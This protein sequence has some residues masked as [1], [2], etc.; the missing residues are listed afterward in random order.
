MIDRMA[1]SPCSLASLPPAP[2]SETGSVKVWTAPVVLS[3]YVPEPAD[4]NPMFF[5]DR[6]SQGASGRVYP[7]PIVERIAE[8]PALCSWEA[9][10][11][12]NE[13]LRLMVLPKLGGRIHLGL[14]KIGGHDFFHFEETIQPTAGERTGPAIFGGLEIDWPHRRRAG[15]FVPCETAIA[16]AADGSATIW[17][18]HHDPVTRMKG[19]HGVCLHP[20]RALVQL[21]ARLYNRTEDAHPFVWSAELSAQVPRS[22]QVFFSPEVKFVSER[23]G[24][25]VTDLPSGKR[26]FASAG[27]ADLAQSD[28]DDEAPRQTIEPLSLCA[29]GDFAGIYDHAVHA[30]IVQV[31][32][33]HATRDR[34]MAASGR[35]GVDFL[36]AAGGAQTARVSLCAGADLEGPTVRSSL[37]PGETR[38]F[39]QYWCPLREIGVP[40]AVTLQGALSLRVEPGKAHIGVCVTADVSDAQVLLRSHGQVVARWQRNITVVQPFVAVGRIAL[41]VAEDSLILTVEQRGS[42]LLRYAPGEVVAAPAPLAVSEPAPPEAIAGGELLYLTGLHLL[43]KRHATRRPEPYWFEAVRRDPG[44]ARANTAL[45]SLLL[46][47]GNFQLAENHLHTAIARLNLLGVHP[48]DSEA[49]YRLGIAL[50][51]QGR[52]QEAYSAFLQGTGNAAW[53]G[54]AYQGLAE[55]DARARRWQKTLEHIDRCLAAGAENLNALAVRAL[56]LRHLDREAEARSQLNQALTLDPLHAWSRHILNRTLPAGGQGRLDLAF[57]YMRC[58][59]LADAVSVL[60]AA[61]STADDDDGSAPMRHYTRAVLL[62]RMDERLLSV[63]VYEIAARL[64]VDYVFPNRTEEMLILEAVL[65]AAPGDAHAPLYLG[66]LLYDRRQYA[67]AIAQWNHAI[68]LDPE[69][70]A[71][72][73]NLG[74]ARYNVQQNTAAAIEAYDAAFAADP[75]SARIAYERDQLLKR[76]AIRPSVR[77]GELLQH[78][79]LP[80]QRDDLSLEL[81]RLLNHTGKPQ[82]ALELLLRR[83]FQ[84]WDGMA[85]MALAEFHRASILIC[86]MALARGSTPYARAVLKAALE[87]PPSLAVPGKRLTERSEVLYWL[88]VATAA[89]GDA[90]E[91]NSIWRRG[92]HSSIDAI[93][94]ASLDLSASSFWVGQCLDALGDHAAATEL[95]DRIQSHALNLE[96]Q[97]TMADYFAT[98]TPG[99]VP[100]DDDAA[101]QNRIEAHLLRSQAALGRRDLNEAAR[102]AQE[103]LLLDPGHAGAWDLRAQLG[104]ERA[105]AHLATPPRRLT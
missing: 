82:Q 14:D 25:T 18:S 105:I 84:P 46:E 44:D 32:S 102:Q 101:Q 103:V 5:E 87:P 29:T 19:M 53:R 90:D 24:R 63:T 81:A 79:E 48:A 6:V 17:L 13:F 92:A 2:A 77:L 67:D 73:R 47:R 59:L 12:E 54:P 39:S 10:H 60:A 104:R 56:A 4:P 98:S 11:I 83:P 31:A 97:P 99:T 20:G 7:Q 88:G 1:P 66:N 40:Q 94:V 62:D 61:V 100:F 68:T 16:R 22:V 8:E 89:N 45:G 36:P 71:A 96:E 85:A 9:I 34:G 74:I 35:Y 78:P 69:L 38:T 43:Q 37:H 3:T 91:A 65:M 64:P 23:S 52:L 51:H 72:H 55:I 30:G 58:G 75:T 70:P 15:V 49:H 50:R 26:P 27:R 86:H 76:A 57:D 21:K 33:H 42:V 93:A 41:D 28:G 95:F 80:P